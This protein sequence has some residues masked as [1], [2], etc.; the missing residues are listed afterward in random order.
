MNIFDVIPFSQIFLINI[1]I[2]NFGCHLQT[3][4]HGHTAIDTEVALIVL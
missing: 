4:V 3:Y 1:T 2:K